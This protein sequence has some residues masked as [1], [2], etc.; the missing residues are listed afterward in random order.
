MQQLQP[1]TDET[2]KEACTI[3]PTLFDEA[4]IQKLEEVVSKIMA[5]CKN[6][7]VLQEIANMVT[8]SQ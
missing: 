6:Q 7:T 4:P 2:F 3:I 1:I 8:S 5:K